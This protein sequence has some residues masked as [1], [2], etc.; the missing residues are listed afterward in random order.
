MIFC[1][2]IAVVIIALLTLGCARSQK[3]L[4]APAPPPL[5]SDER[6]AQIRQKLSRQEPM[7]IVAPVVETP[8]DAQLAAPGEVSVDQFHR[9]D[10]IT[11]IDSEM[12]VIDT[13]MVIKITSDQVH[14]RY[15]LPDAAHRQPRV[16]DLG[17]LVPKH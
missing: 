15:D 16:G 9:G 4:A 1:R 2:W 6:L 17:V 12:N 5:S 13:G 14:V 3:T 10:I 8:A 7:A 11:S